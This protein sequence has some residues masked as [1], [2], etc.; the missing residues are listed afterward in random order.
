V[1]E[2]TLLLTTEERDRL[3]VLHEV[4]QGHIT[5]RCAAKQLRLS[6]RQVRRL[7]R[8]LKRKGD[9]GVVH[10]LRGRPS[11]RKI[12]EKTE[13]RAIALVR[14]KY[15]DF[16]PTLASE[17]L[18]K[19][20]GIVVSRETLRG[21]MMEAGIWRSRRQRIEEVHLWRRRR[22][23]WGEL[24]QWDM[25]D[26]DWLE[27]R[28]ERIY[29]IALI[30][31]A[32]SRVFARFVRHDS[33][34]ENL[35]L[36]WEYLAR[37]GRPLEIYTDYDTVFAVSKGQRARA[38]REGWAEAPQTQFGRALQ[39]LAIGWI[40]ARS[41]EAKGRVERHFQTAQD[42]LV[43]GMRLAG[44]KTLEAANGYLEQEFLPLWNDRFTVE[45][46]NA[47]DAHRPLRAEHDLAAI[48]SEVQSRIVTND[49]T[50]RLDGKVYQ[51]ARADISTG[52]RKATVRV[53]K[54]LDG[55]VAVRFRDRYLHVTLCEPRAQA[56]SPPPVKTTAR[57]K[58]GRRYHDWNK[59]FDLHKAPPIWAAVRASG[60]REDSP[61]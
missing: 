39:E 54:R 13:Q 24:L 18:A 9:R 48:L 33:R 40:G 11:N 25:S 5:Q 10:A 56:A 30:D 31:D 38:A 34:E 1:Q 12:A 53:E 23:C 43:K 29:Y 60:A 28:G 35:K 32:T 41:P 26:H 50:V 8:R 58:P 19:D 46:A 4:Q 57:R 15:Q 3:K 14:R 55:T 7:V 6:A 47:T 59:N 22:S 49:Y 44:V 2:D 61:W 20:D 42:R 52:L 37:H 16:G 21:W 17:Y 36:L 27:G 45:P 51:I